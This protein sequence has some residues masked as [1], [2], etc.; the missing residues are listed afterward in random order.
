MQRSAWL[1]AAAV[2]V[3]CVW[4]AAPAVAGAATFSNSAT[5]TI[6]ATGTSGPAAPYPS[7]IDVSALVGPITN[8]NVTLH[9][10]SHT[11][12]EDVSVLLAGPTAA[13]VVLMGGPGGTVDASNLTFTFSD[14]AAASLPCGDAVLTSGTYK[15]NT[16]FPGDIFAAPA[17]A[18][19]YGAALSGFDG[20]DANG[21]WNLYVQDFGPGDTGSISGGWSLD[22][23]TVGTEISDLQDL[24]A[25]MGIHHGITNALESKLQHA[26]DALAA[27]NT[28]G[29]CYW[30]QSSVQL[31]NAQT[32]K[33]ITPG[34]ADQLASAAADIQTQLGC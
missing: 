4:L 18:K 14:A 1:L 10:F 23:T 17:P 7:T 15:P 24:V 12:P 11:A 6:P 5:V 13:S 21:T 3:T 25:S 28:G 29:A 19:P 26:L 8:V 30:M 16:C 27:D 33:K 9:G 34:Q 31:V 32:G 20:T 2:A 22:I